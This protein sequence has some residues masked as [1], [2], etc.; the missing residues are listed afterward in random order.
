MIS[1]AD[2]DP[3]TVIVFVS[4][5][6]CEEAT[7]TSAFTAVSIVFTQC[8]QDIFSMAKF[9][10]LLSFYRCAAKLHAVEWE[11]GASSDWKV[12]GNFRYS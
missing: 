7:P 11:Y 6:A 10:I 8:P 9:F 12:K 5:F 1:A 4:R 2:A 3:V